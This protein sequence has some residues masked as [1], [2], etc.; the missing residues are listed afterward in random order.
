MRIKQSEDLPELSAVTTV[1]RKTLNQKVHEA[2]KL[3][4]LQGKIAPGTKMNEVQI[5][6]QMNTSTTPVR[7][8]FRMLAAEG[9][10]K[11]EP[12]KGVVVTEYQT[13]EILE[14]FQCREAL[15]LLALELTMR[16]LEKSPQREEEIRKID[17]EIE[18]SR[19]SGLTE[20]VNL[21]SGIH[22]FWIRGSGNRRLMQLIE[23]M[24]DVLLHDRNVSAMDETRRTQIIEEHVAILEAIRDQDEDK[25]KSALLEHIRRGYE[26]SLAIRK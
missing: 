1:S 7:E 16:Q 21:N 12:W 11:I 2:L 13:D 25:A 19:S 6:H 23:T 8:A 3:L 24:N 20:F 14:V 18:R 26:Y 22:D 15:E 9:L 10:V 4:I 17:L 5:A